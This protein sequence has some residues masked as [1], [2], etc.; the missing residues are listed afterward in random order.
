M[1]DQEIKRIHAAIHGR[2]QGVGFRYFVTEIASTHHIT[3]WT[4]NR[5]NGTVEVVGEGEKQNLEQFLDALRRGPRASNVSKVDFEWLDANGEF[6]SFRV[7][8]TG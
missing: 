3:G 4:R 1:K 6:E 8:R 2:V 7:K 5:W